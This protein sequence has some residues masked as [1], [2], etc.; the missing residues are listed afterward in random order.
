MEDGQTRRLALSPRSGRRQDVPVV[1]RGLVF[2]DGDAVV[3]RG[4][5]FVDGD[6]EWLDC[7]HAVSL[8]RGRRPSRSPYSVRLLGGEVRSLLAGGNDVA[9]TISGV[10]R[11]DAIDVQS[12]TPGPGPMLPAARLSRPPC[13]PPLGGWPH[14]GVDENLV[15]DAA[16]LLATGA[17][18]SVAM[19]RPSRDQVVLVVTASEAGAVESKL[20]PVLG[21]RLCV[22]QSRWTRA[23]VDEVEQVLLGHRRDWMVDVVGVGMEDQGQ[24]V[25]HAFLVRVSSAIADWAET[26]DDGLLR[27]EPSI[28]PA[29]MRRV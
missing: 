19:F 1:A 14:G 9:A 28:V 20:R 26:I 23:R 7:I 18:V 6:G 21:A 29:D 16:D 12:V 4:L 25:V 27:L 15:F 13:P 8:A 3:G 10:W 17:A 2:G 5:L 11:G 24:P 22:V